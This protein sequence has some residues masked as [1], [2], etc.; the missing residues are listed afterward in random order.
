MSELGRLIVRHRHVGPMV[1][2]LL[3]GMDTAITI[4]DVGGEAIIVRSDTRA[5]TLD[6]LGRLP[7]KFAGGVQPL[8]VFRA[9]RRENVAIAG[10]VHDDL[11]E[12]R[13][14]AGLALEDDAAHR[15]AATSARP[16]AAS[17]RSRKR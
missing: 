3:A 13:L 5:R 4:R 17:S 9:R 10:G 8:L 7:V 2:A 1:S 12:H 14:P 11:C 15:A 16:R 6:D